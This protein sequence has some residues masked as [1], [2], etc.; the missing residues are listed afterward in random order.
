[1][2][3]VAGLPLVHNDGTVKTEGAVWEDASRRENESVPLPSAP[4]FA[5][6]LLEAALG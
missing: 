1:M 2:V 6:S 5:L 4:L 3:R